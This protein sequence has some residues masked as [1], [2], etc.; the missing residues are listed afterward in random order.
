MGLFSFFKRENNYEEILSGL[1][2]DIKRAEKQRALAVERMEGW[3]YNWLFYVGFAWLAYL[4]GFVLYVWPERYGT[5]ASGFLMHSTLV[6]TIPL[7]IYYGNL[8]IRAAW[9]RVIDR[10]DTRIKRLRE[11][12]KERLDELKKK[13]AFDTTK[14]LIDKY[15]AGEKTPAVERGQA[16]RLKQEAKDR[17]RTMPNFGTPGSQNFNQP[18]PQQASPL[19]AK[20]QRGVNPQQQQTSLGLRDTTPIISS[21]NGML[22][23]SSSGELRHNDADVGIVKVTPRGSSLNNIDSGSGS[24]PWLDKLVDQL[25][26]DVG[27]DKDKYALICRYCYA[28]NGLV[29]EEEIRDIQY[30]CPKCGK[31][32]PSIRALHSGANLEMQPPTQTQQRLS[33]QPSQLPQQEQKQQRLVR[34]RELPSSNSDDGAVSAGD[35]DDSSSDSSKFDEPE[36]PE[37]QEYQ[38]HKEDSAYNESHR[39]ADEQDSHSGSDDGEGN[40]TDDA[41]SSLSTPVTRSRALRNQKSKESLKQ[42][43]PKQRSSHANSI[44]SPQHSRSGSKNSNVSGQTSRKRRG[45]AKGKRS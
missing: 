2:L 33:Q 15:T 1:E 19:A 40:T 32:N 24:R 28:H 44:K 7:V 26:G 5:Q 36:K 22:R 27:S 8:G 11:E 30:T 37:K 6:A 39:S 17:R 12:L 35:L 45:G 29:L 21:N 43:A 4:L 25:V 23:P 42:S 13:T 20:S 31:F 16:A 34:H 18:N 9:R 41:H 14:N 3:A 10:H 38:K